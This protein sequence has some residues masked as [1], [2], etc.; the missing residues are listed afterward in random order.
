MKVE[1]LID[2]TDKIDAIFHEYGY[3]VDHDILSHHILR[4]IKDSYPND[5]I[6]LE[7]PDLASILG[8]SNLKPLSEVV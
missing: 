3:S 8:T 2:I 4:T 1:E 6:Q 7:S 5:D